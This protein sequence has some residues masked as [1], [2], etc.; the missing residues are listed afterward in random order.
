[1]AQRVSS[2]VFAGRSR[3][4]AELRAAM[5][6]AVD[7]APT[8]VLVG[9]EAG[10]GKSRLLSEVA[11]Q[12][13]GA[14]VR[15]LPG[16]CVSLEEAAI[17]LL[18]VADVLRHLSGDDRSARELLDAVTSPLNGSTSSQLVAGPSAR[19]HTLVRDRL[20]RAS[21]SSPVLLALEDLQWAD[22]STLDLVAFLARRLRRERILVVA[23]YRSDEVARRDDLQRF[24]ADVSSAA[25]VERI[26]LTGLTRSEMQDLVAGI[27]GADPAPDLV[28]DVFARSEGNPFFAEEL[29]AATGQGALSPTL[30]DTLLARIGTLDSGGQTVV[31]VAAAGGREVHHRL[32]AAA[33]ALPEPAL[34]EALRSAVSHHVLEAREDG[35][36]FRHALLQEVVYAE[37][38]PGERARLH[39][40]FAAAL[41]ARHDLAGGNAATVAAEIAHHWLRAGD[42]P[43]ALAAAVR[44]GDEAERIG[45]FAEAARHHRR[46]LELWDVVAEPDRPVGIDR[47]TL[48]A[49]AANAPAWTGDPADAIRLVEA[50]IALV[51]PAAEPV[52][53]ALLH[54]RR[55]I[56]LWQLG[57][58]EEGARDLERAVGLIPAE[59]P[60]PERARALGGLG[61]I[62][63]LAGE[64]ARSRVQCEAAVAVAHAVGARVEEADALATLGD[65]L[66]R[67]GDLPAGL[68]C[69]REARAL[70]AETG[71]SEPLSRI[72]VPLSDQLRRDGRLAESVEVA[73]SGARE[74]RRAGLDARESFCE[75]NAAE[76]AYELG[77]WELAD[78]LAREV[79]ARAPTGVTLAFA[80]HIAGAL[81][82]ARGELGAAEAH[83][84]AQR[85][86]TGRAAPPDYY[87]IEAEAE[88]ALGQGR[89]EAAS[90]AA[91][92]GV[93]V[94]APDALRGMVMAALGARAEA[95]RAELARARRDPVTEASACGGARAFRD[96]A[97][98]RAGAA[99]HPALAAS[100]EAEHARAEGD[101]DPALWDAVARLWDARAAR[102]HAAYARWRQAE[103][104]V[105][106]RDRA[107]SEPALL[108]AHAV[109][110]GLGAAP[111]RAELEA[112]ARRARIDLTA[113]V[114]ANPVSGAAATA[115]ELG[116]TARE[117]E[118]LEQLALGRTNRQIADELFISTKTA[119]VHV[120]HILRK[121][122]AANRSEAAAIAHR[123]GLVP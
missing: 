105:A 61:L 116:L 53:A 114:P 79:L 27:L 55:G 41:D 112:L 44:A 13:A 16:Q 86:A 34:T 18:P 11:T 89:H 121:L 66:S 40:A 43:R 22:R 8:V 51:D 12:A 118:V 7:G 80:H 15:V 37:L 6:R 58:A 52:R 109:A 65:D 47:A 31:R 110:V 26:E 123:L 88:L 24:L 9:G 74:A 63:M 83:L 76:A 82:R 54:Q 95:D 56:L 98:E 59:P 96:A 103:A 92:R 85:D 100:A 104:A 81:A 70:A 1:M 4:L 35:F 36:A 71:D 108:A 2:S 69:L 32:L 21:A 3:E 101:G 73:L 25:I 17:P 62:L 75:L 45:A 46:A 10:I 5:A 122:G 28:D 42:R 115:A 113:G 49:R 97:V 117:R 99:R 87:D 48:L 29:M 30:R 107:Q 68:R 106:R 91:R 19:L 50:A 64:P 14:G 67:L 94:T 93:H 120:S 39:S 20:E 23:T 119:V 111:L 77:D 57:R 84:A 90:D 78:R 33:A 102:Y 38:L 72:A 60:S